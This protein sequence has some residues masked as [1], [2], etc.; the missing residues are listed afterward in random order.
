MKSSEKNF[1]YYTAEGI[2]AEKLQ[3]EYVRTRVRSHVAI[4]SNIMSGGS[5]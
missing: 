3:K 2:A 4:V 5:W 1:Y